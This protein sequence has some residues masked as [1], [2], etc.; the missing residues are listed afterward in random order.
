M[1]LY[2]V[3]GVGGE[4]GEDLV[5]GFGVIG[6]V[7]GGGD[8]VGGAGGAGGEVGEDF[9]REGDDGGG[10]FFAG[11][12]AGLVVGVDVD[13]LGVEADG[14][15]EEGDEDADGAG[16]DFVDGEGEVFA[17]VFGEGGAGALEEAVKVV[18][19]GNAGVNEEGRGV[20]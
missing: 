6:G 15:F 13:E 20:K 3:V 8:L 5:D 19:G 2:G 4:V 17:G 11:F 16:G 12:D 1:G 7:E 10:G 9:R 14:T 18:A